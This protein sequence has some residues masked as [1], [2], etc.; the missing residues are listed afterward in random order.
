MIILPNRIKAYTDCKTR[1]EFEDFMFVKYIQ[2]KIIKCSCDDS[3]AENFKDASSHYQHCEYFR[4]CHGITRA[5]DWCGKK[6]DN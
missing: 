1:K 5:L 2:S 4:F 6:H 3:F